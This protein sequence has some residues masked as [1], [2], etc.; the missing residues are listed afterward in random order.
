MKLLLKF[1]D[2]AERT[3]YFFYKNFEKKTREII[4]KPI[5]IS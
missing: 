2:T 1:L 3:L 5:G 4:A